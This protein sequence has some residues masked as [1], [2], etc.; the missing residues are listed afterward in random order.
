MNE[1]EGFVRTLKLHHCDFTYHSSETNL[2]CSDLIENV[3]GCAGQFK[4]L[5]DYKKICKPITQQLHE[6]EVVK[7]YKYVIKGKMH[8]ISFM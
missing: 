7:N 4:H 8:S 6:T 5:I 3:L 1:S 2:E